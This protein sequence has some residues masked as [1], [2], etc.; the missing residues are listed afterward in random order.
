MALCYT[1]ILA[2][3][4]SLGKSTLPRVA[5]LLDVAQISEIVGIESVDTF[6]RPTYAGNVLVTLRSAD[7]LKVITVRTT[8]F[9]PLDISGA[10][11]V[12]MIPVG[13]DAGLSRVI[14]RELQQVRTARA[15]CCQSGGI[16][17]S[18]FG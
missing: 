10:A 2:P 3:A 13:S 14:K 4:T 5:A 11:Q 18:G 1:H 8:A 15:Q 7:P 17:W 9:D 12:E 16:R 6:V